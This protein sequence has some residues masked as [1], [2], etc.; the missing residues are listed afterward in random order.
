MIFKPTLIASLFFLLASQTIQAIAEENSLE[1]SAAPMLDFVNGT[2]IYLYQ[3]NANNFS[4]FMNHYN[5]DEQG[6]QAANPIRLVYV[7]VGD[8]R[9]PACN[10]DKTASVYN[11]TMPYKIANTALGNQVACSIPSDFDSTKGQVPY[12]S[13]GS[14]FSPLNAQAAKGYYRATGGSLFNAKTAAL[15]N[16]AL[17]RHLLPANT[18]K[19]MALMGGRIDNGYLREFNKLST[20]QAQELANF[21][22]FGATVTANPSL[23]SPK[24]SSIPSPDAISYSISTSSGSN[25]GPTYSVTGI[26]NDPNL[27]GIQTNLQP[28]D[29]KGPISAGGQA[30]FYDQLGYDMSL[31]KKRYSVQALPSEIKKAIINKFNFQAYNNF[32]AEYRLY[33]LPSQTYPEAK[34]FPMLVGLSDSE[35]PSYQYCINASWSMNMNIQ[36]CSLPNNSASGLVYLPLSQSTYQADLIEQLSIITSAT[37]RTLPFKVSISAAASSQEFQTWTDASGH[38]LVE[39]PDPHALLDYVQQ[40]FFWVNNGVGHYSNFYGADLVGFGLEKNNQW[41]PNPIIVNDDN[42]LTTG[43]YSLFYPTNPSPEVLAFVRDNNPKASRDNYPALGATQGWINVDS[44]TI[45]PVSNAPNQS[46]YLYWFFMC[47]KN[48]LST[49]AGQDLIMHAR[50]FSNPSG[51]IYNTTTLPQEVF[52]T[53]YD[54]TSGYNTTEIQVPSQCHTFQST[55]ASAGSSNVCFP[56]V[57]LNAMYNQG[58]DSAPNNKNITPTESYTWTPAPSSAD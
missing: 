32:Y 18:I 50:F 46:L 57:S 22:A 56:T 15:N 52:C 23:R 3:D 51:F 43:T 53:P 28:F 30:A 55:P 42:V 49:S 24:V 11:I 21:I 4:S 41:S 40:A 14:N 25:S 19:Y 35:S 8:L 58:T 38:V 36:N 26:C 44:S 31:C 45:P 6:N 7:N 54:L 12:Y 48:S 1:L 2:G 34:R 29:I 27:L 5:F 39:N 13:Y 9:F 47:P 20:R 37:L 33:D 16:S 10:N 17:I